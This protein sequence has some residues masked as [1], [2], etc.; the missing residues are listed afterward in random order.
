M[1]TAAYLRGCAAARMRQ[2]RCAYCNRA[3]VAARDAGPLMRTRDH[4]LPRAHGRSPDVHN[5]RPACWGCNQL[6][7]DLGH[8]VGALMLAL[9][10]GGRRRLPAPDAAVA[11]GMKAMRVRVADP[12]HDPARFARLPMPLPR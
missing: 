5:V 10:E 8:C 7:A 2:D 4:I 12:P 3:T 9:I 11:L 6:R 1:M